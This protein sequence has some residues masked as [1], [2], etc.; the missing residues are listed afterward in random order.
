L[1][2]P[3]R[4]L[5]RHL[6]GELARVYLVAG[7]EPLLVDEAVDQIRVAARRDGFDGRELYTIDRGFR[8]AE[9]E[10]QADNL[11]LF[12]SRKV[13][14]LRLPTPRPGDAG[15]RGITSMSEREDADTLLIVAVGER[16]DSVASRS[17]WV[18][19]IDTHGVVV[20]IWPI[21]RRELPRW[22][23]RRAAAA[24]LKLTAAA[25][26]VLAERVE[27]NLLAADQEIQRLALTAAGREIDEGEVLESV[28]NNSRF[29]AFTLAD[30]VL[31]GDAARAFKILAGLRREGVT[32]VLVSWALA[33]D[34]AVLARLQ[35]AARHRGDLDQALARS[36][37]WRR[38]QP[39]VKQ[40][41]RR[42]GVG[43]LG[44]LLVRAAEV[45]ATLKGLRSGEPWTA[46]TDLL[47]ALLM[48]AA[49]TA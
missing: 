38:R 46:L 49:K 34:I 16:L 24:Q 6:E 2:V 1:K 11:S 13:L 7:D 37:V 22:V 30:A 15:S 31:A 20:E 12:A 8:W 36:G 41:L 10:A 23:E 25:A 47:L 45:D 18:K 14:E 4:Q 21:E 26:Q 39:L 29:D 43:R 3:L 17:A 27:G 32:P 42:Y 5:E 33:R 35:Y 48:P 28:A 19:S 40:A 44:D 9:L